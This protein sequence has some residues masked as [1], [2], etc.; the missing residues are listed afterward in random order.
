M[1]LTYSQL[2]RGNRNFRNLLW[3]QFVSEM[4]NWFNFIA[5]LGTRASGVG[6]FADRRRD[7]VCLPD[8]AVCGF[9]ADCRDIR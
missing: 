1:N 6:R 7:F 5:G 2:I 4:G 9:F 8:F 3:G